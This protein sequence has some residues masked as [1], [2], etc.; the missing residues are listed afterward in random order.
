MP[1]GM[2]EIGPSFRISIPIAGVIVMLLTTLLAGVAVSIL[3]AGM[4]LTMLLAGVA[5]NMLSEGVGKAGKGMANVSTFTAGT[6]F[7]TSTTLTGE[8]SAS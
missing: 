5:V 8:G 6:P 7:R 2:G 4:G 3:S 1:I